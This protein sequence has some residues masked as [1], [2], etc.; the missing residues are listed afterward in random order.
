MSTSLL[1]IFLF[2][3]YSIG[4]TCTPNSSL[5]D[6]LQDPDLKRMLQQPIRPSVNE[7][8][9]SRTELIQEEI[10][11]AQADLAKIQAD[12]KS[13]PAEI[14]SAERRLEYLHN[15]QEQAKIDETI[16]QNAGNKE[17]SDFIK[18]MMRQKVSPR[19]AN[20]SPQE[21]DVDALQKLDPDQNLPPI[22]HVP[23]PTQADLD[24]FNDF[25]KQPMIS[26]GQRNTYDNFISDLKVASEQ[27]PV[28]AQMKDPISGKMTDVSV[29][30]HI[31]SDDLRDYVRIRFKTSD[32]RIVHRNVSAE[33][34][35]FEGKELSGGD[36]I[37]SSSKLS[38][39]TNEQRA[40]ISVNT[41]SRHAM[42]K[43][44]QE[45]YLKLQARLDSRELSIEEMIAV[46]SRQADLT[47]KYSPLRKHEI[48][49][50]EDNLEGLL[51]GEGKTLSASDKRAIAQIREIIDIR[52]GNARSLEDQALFDRVGDLTESSLLTR[53]LTQSRSNVIA[54]IKSL[55]GSNDHTKLPFELTRKWSSGEV[56]RAIGGITGKRNAADAIKVISEFEK[57]GQIYDYDQ[58]RDLTKAIRQLEGDLRGKGAL[59]SPSSQYLEYLKLRVENYNLNLKIEE[60]KN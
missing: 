56:S 41:L 28:S 13:T 17:D 31:S 53:R 21:I 11:V 32:G 9:P 37:L 15:K 60:L 45:E 58:A 48:E 29:I 14:K 46:T 2:I 16:E 57:R 24:A 23:P 26:R 35:S 59:D 44:D 30:E 20:D 55:T 1:M 42:Y 47:K 12:Y 27:Y 3:Q 34:L 50:I 39:L 6:L 51:N 38:D 25:L 10:D 7:P 49:T 36:G 22:K 54:E 18:M 52:D 43:T 5:D 8:L 4:A 40:Q 19:L 33:T